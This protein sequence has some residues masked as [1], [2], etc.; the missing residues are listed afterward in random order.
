MSA[1]RCS[2]AWQA[3]AHEDGRLS[4]QDAASFERHVATCDVCGGEVEA[5]AQLKAAAEQLPVLSSTPLEHRRLRQEVLRKAHE[6]STGERRSPRLAWLA[7]ASAFALAASAAYVLWFRAPF[8]PPVVSSMPPA[9]VAPEY[10]ASASAD[11]V[12]HTRQPGR[13][14]RLALERGR[15]ELTVTRLKPDQR[16]IVE[17]PDGE[18]E[19]KGTRFVVQA[20]AARTTTVRVIEGRVALRLREKPE[21]MLEAGDAFSAAVIEEAAPRQD[22]S[23]ES[24]APSATRAPQDPTN[25]TTIEREENTKARSISEPNTERSTKITKV[26]RKSNT[27]I[28]ESKSESEPDTAES[29]APAPS[30]PAESTFSRAMSAFEAGDFGR[31]DSLF[32]QFEREQPRDSRVEDALFLRALARSRRGDHEGARVIALEYLARF[33]NGLR[34]ADAE[35]LAR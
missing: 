5:L 11:A 6:A 26:A 2:R 17:L 15:L 1:Q 22:T 8:I 18:L 28:S 23:G 31:A 7:A 25:P 3:E 13:V 16:F 12:W 9:Q 14:L 21:A 20:E 33:P 24:R 32:H 34:K 4:K 30:P 29:P 27:E 35:R 10:E 19:V